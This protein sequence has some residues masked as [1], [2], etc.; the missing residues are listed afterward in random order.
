MTTKEIGGGEV[1]SIKHGID[2]LEVVSESQRAMLTYA[3]SGNIVML[4]PKYADIGQA[5]LNAEEIA[6]RCR[7]H[8]R[9]VEALGLILDDYRDACEEWNAENQEY[10]LSVIEKADTLL[11]E[12]SAHNGG[13]G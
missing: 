13:E 6:M 8:D 4:S 5:K 9:L 7:Y 1:R 11:A 2:N 12:L 10:G 3:D